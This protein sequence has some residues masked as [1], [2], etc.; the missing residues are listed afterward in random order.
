[1]THEQTAEAKQRLTQLTVWAEQAAAGSPVRPADAID[2]LIAFKRLHPCRDDEEWRALWCERRQKLSLALVIE[3]DRQWAAHSALV[4]QLLLL[5]DS[6][7]SSSFRGF[8]R[9]LVPIICEYV[10]VDLER[11]LREDTSSSIIAPSDASSAEAAA[12]LHETE[13]VT[14]A[15]ASSPSLS[16]E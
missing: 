4:R 2:E 13:S 8:P 16:L 11:P 14:D 10:G 6:T 1:M 5:G 7:P 12:A 9:D 3:L 15:A